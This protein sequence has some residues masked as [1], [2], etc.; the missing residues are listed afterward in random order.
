MDTDDLDTTDLLERYRSNNCDLALALN[1]L[2]AELYTSKQRLLLKERELQR[3]QEDIAHLRSDLSQRDTKLNEWRSMF[4]E[5]MQANTKKYTEIMAKIGFVTA[6]QTFANPPK[7]NERP[8][9]RTPRMDALRRRR[10]SMDS[11]CKLSNVT[12]ESID[13]TSE[14][15]MSKA[16][17]TENINARRRAQSPPRKLIIRSDNTVDVQR[18]D[19]KSAFS[20]NESLD[21]IDNKENAQINAGGRPSRRTAP[22]NLA[23]PKLGTKLRRN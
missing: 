9:P 3:A 7:T 4:I 2:K 21:S 14:S 5:L 18:T 1:D 20:S 15:S 11:P 6:P 22:K 19:D 10:H 13:N 8:V 17:N 12:E 23:E 16:N